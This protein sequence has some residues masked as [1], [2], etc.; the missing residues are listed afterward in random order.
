VWPSHRSPMFLLLPPGCSPDDT[1]AFARAAEWLGGGAGH[2]VSRW[3]PSPRTQPVPMAL[4]QLNLKVP[5]AV[6]AHWQ[7]EA[8]GAGL[9]I[10]DWLIQQTMP[11]APPPSLPDPGLAERVARLERQV[12]D[13][14]TRPVTPASSPARRVREP[15][16]SP[17]PTEGVEGSTVAEALDIPRNAWN[18]RVRRAGGARPG[19]VVSGWRCVGFRPPRMGGPLRA[20]WVPDAGS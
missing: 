6:R 2:G 19:L 13:L 3:V 15:A 5:E 12:T 1:A 7:R 9:S 11:G 8:H 4:V 17:A 10:R 14:L 20:L 18:A 16:P